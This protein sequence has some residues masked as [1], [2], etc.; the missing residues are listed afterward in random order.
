MA[1]AVS[2]SGREVR[3]VGVDILVGLDVR[4]RSAVAVIKSR[5]GAEKEEELERGL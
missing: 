1:S 4:S 2:R 3:L 5:V